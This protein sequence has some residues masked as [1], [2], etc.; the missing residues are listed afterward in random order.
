MVRSHALALKYHVFPE[1]TPSVALSVRLHEDTDIN[2]SS[3]VFGTMD[4][5]IGDSY[6]EF[7]GLLQW[8]SF[9]QHMPMANLEREGVKLGRANW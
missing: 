3:V 4:V 9:F 6:D 8:V 5:N 2:D 1:I 7:T